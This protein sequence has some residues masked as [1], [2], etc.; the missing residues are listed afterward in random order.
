VSEIPTNFQESR[1]LNLKTTALIALA[2]PL[3]GCASYTG[4][5]VDNPVAA[6]ATPPK[7]ITGQTA[8]YW[9]TYT[10]LDKDIIDAWRKTG[11]FQEVVTTS[12]DVPPAQGTFIRTD[13]T[14]RIEGVTP[15]IF[16]LM[17]FLTLGTVPGGADLDRY[18]CTTKFYQNGVKLSETTAQHTFKRIYNSWIAWLATSEDKVIGD[19]RIA[20]ASN[21][22]STQVADLKKAYP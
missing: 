13:C 17:T 14:H 2:L 6:P 4:M 8:S 10:G 19:G 3:F 11:L 15:A 21:I 22:V 9:G 16:G 12:S 18:V 5:N 1:P 7:I 20:A